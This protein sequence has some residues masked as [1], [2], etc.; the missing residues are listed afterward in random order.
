MNRDQGESAEVSI[1]KA[2]KVDERVSGVSFLRVSPGA[3]MEMLAE[4][5]IW[6]DSAILLS[7]SAELGSGRTGNMLSDGKFET[8]YV[9]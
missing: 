7:S 4:Y 5:I 8:D 3:G 2:G 9:E 6:V 1:R